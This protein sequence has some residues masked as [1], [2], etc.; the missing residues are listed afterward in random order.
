MKLGFREFVAAFGLDL[1]LV[2]ARNHQMCQEVG[3]E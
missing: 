2:S 1:V 3:P